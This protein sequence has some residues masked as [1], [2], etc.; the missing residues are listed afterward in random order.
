MVGSRLHFGQ[1]ISQ[2]KYYS[3]HTHRLQEECIIEEVIMDKVDGPAFL[4]PCSLN[5][6][7]K[8]TLRK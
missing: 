6:D 8:G 5:H 2:H 3:L 4:I 7:I 1:N